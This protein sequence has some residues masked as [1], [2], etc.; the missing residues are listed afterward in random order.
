[1]EQCFWSSTLGR[2]GYLR[3]LGKGIFLRSGLLLLLLGVRGRR[4]CETMMR[5]ILLFSGKFHHRTHTRI[6]WR[7]GGMVR[8][9]PLS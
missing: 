7:A 3:V 6:I 1:M 4:D 9:G 8:L 5:A 2:S